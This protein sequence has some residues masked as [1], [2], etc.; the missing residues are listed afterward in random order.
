[1]RNGCI[2]LKPHGRSQY[3]AATDEVCQ[4][5]WEPKANEHLLTEQTFIGMLN[6]G[7]IVGQS[8]STKGKGKGDTSEAKGKGK[9]KDGSKGK[10]KS[11]SKSKGKGAS[12]AWSAVAWNAH[13]KWEN[14]QKELKEL[15]KKVA[16]NEKK[17]AD[18]SPDT[19]DK[20]EAQEEPKLFTRNFEGKK[21]PVVHS[22]ACG[23]QLWA[24]PKNKKCP[25][26]SC[27][28]DLVLP[29]KAPAQRKPEGICFA[30]QKILGNLD[31]GQGPAKL[32]PDLRQLKLANASALYDFAVQQGQDA[33]TLELLKKKHDALKDEEPPEDG[34]SYKTLSDIESALKKQDAYWEKAEIKL[35]TQA[36]SL[37]AAYDAAEAA[38]QA[39]VKHMKSSEASHFATKTSLTKQREALLKNLQVQ[40]QPNQMQQ[41]ATLQAQPVTEQAVQQAQIPPITAIQTVAALKLDAFWAA[42]PD[43]AQ[44]RLMFTDLFTKMGNFVSQSQ[45]SQEEAARDE[46]LRKRMAEQHAMLEQQEREKQEVAAKVASEAAAQQQEVL[47]VQEQQR[48]QVAAE[49]GRVA[50]ATAKDLLVHQELERNQLLAK[51]SGAVAASSHLDPS[52]APEVAPPETIGQ[53]SL[54]DQCQAKLKGTTGNMIEKLERKLA[55]KSKD[56]EPDTKTEEGMELDK[57]E[58]QDLK[59]LKTDA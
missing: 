47:R 36:N 3:N 48:L 39:H 12:I 26:P 32:D 43:A 9:G 55:H 2:G 44:N 59:K 51:Q 22:C 14:V 17:T 49:Q 37:S 28:I 50:A 38:L 24:I 18:G 5:C 27:G 16:E 41:Q 40:G 25:E 21:V 23:N 29:E 53:M 46:E 58:D 10:G 4:R 19:P 57:I 35:D 15:R 54:F 30:A 11:P 13:Q 1:M 52:V 20:Q 33:E 34:V 6:K 42:N 7:Q 31:Q 45:A 8:P 56:M